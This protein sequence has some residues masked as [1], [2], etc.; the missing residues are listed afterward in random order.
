MQRAIGRGEKREGEEEEKKCRRWTCFGSGPLEDGGTGHTSTR[1]DE[2]AYISTQNWAVSRS[3]ARK[4][5]LFLDIQV[6]ITH[7]VLYSTVLYRV[8]L[9]YVI[10]VCDWCVCGKPDLHLPVFTQ[11][12]NHYQSGLKDL[13]AETPEIAL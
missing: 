3:T 6:I 5:S 2:G 1:S 12:V 10:S 8:L 13:V 11:T 9:L 7:Y 4:Y